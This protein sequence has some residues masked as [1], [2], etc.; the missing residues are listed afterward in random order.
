MDDLNEIYDK[1]KDIINNQEPNNSQQSPK[2]PQNQAEEKPK[3][4]NIEHDVY[5]TNAKK[6]K[7]EKRKLQQ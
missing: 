3:R 2:E 7:A 4:P 6:I 5:I 1:T